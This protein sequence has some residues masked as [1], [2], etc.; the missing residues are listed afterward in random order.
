MR[1]VVVVLAAVLA[2]L[3]VAGCTNGTAPPTDTPAAG[4]TDTPATGPTAPGSP[5]ATPDASDGVLIVDSPVLAP[6]G[7]IPVEHTCDG[8]DVPVPLRYRGVPADAQ[9]VVVVVDDPDAPGGT[10]VHWLLAGLPGS[11]GS[12]EEAPASAITGRNDFGGQGWDGP[13]PP[14]GD[15]PHT[16]RFRVL[17]FDRTLGLSPGFTIADLHAGPNPVAEGTLT[18][19]YGR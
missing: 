5:T 2:A 15:T 13:C 12:I 8:A 9:E 16:Y 18:G 10:F 1:P 7:P 4:P 17:A 14:P 6:A 3:A 19:T 11:D